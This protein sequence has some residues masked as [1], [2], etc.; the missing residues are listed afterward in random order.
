V[1]S[2]RLAIYDVVLRYFRYGN[3][4]LAQLAPGGYEKKPPRAGSFL[5][6]RTFQ[7][8]EGTR[9]YVASPS[10]SSPWFN[11]EYVNARNSTT[12]SPLTEVGPEPRATHCSI[13]C[14]AEEIGSLKAG[15]ESSFRLG[16]LLG[17]VGTIASQHQPFCRAPEPFIMPAV[18]CGN[19]I[20]PITPN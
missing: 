18:A 3:V 17:R 4:A 11:H 19:K 7:R 15:V 16:G 6:L 20:C 9:T 1:T 12:S 10:A 13:R 8:Y 14:L 5:E 2:L